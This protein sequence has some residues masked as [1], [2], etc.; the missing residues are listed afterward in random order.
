MARVSIFLTLVLL[1]A[2]TAA[3][4]PRASRELHDLHFGEALYHAYQGEWFEAISRLDTELMQHYGLDEPELDSLYRHVG[5]AEFDVGD[6]ELAYRMHRRAGRAISAVIEG[7]VEAAVRNGA[8]YRLARIYFHKDQPLQAL[9]ALERIQGPVPTE[10]RDDLPFL[11]AQALM[12]SGRFEEAIPILQQLHAARRLEGFTGYN[13][14]VAL[15]SNGQERQGRQVLY[16]TGQLRSDDP[17][18]L[19]IRDKANMVLG[20][21]LLDEADFAAA[22]EVLDRVRLDGPFSNRALLGS[23][24]ADASAGR[25]ER[26]LV[27]WNVLFEREVTDGAVQEALLAV[28]YAYGKLGVY[29]RSALLYG[30]VLETIASEIDKLGAS[31]QSILEGR[32]LEALTREELRHD[33]DW[34]VKLRQLPDSPETYYLLELLASH[35]FQE[36]LRNYLDLDEL[37]DKLEAWRGD[38]DAYEEII[39]LRR[40]YYEPLLPE[41]DS[42]FQ[43]ADSQ[44]RLRLEQRDRVAQ[45]LQNLLVSPHPDSLATAEER[46]ARERLARLERTPGVPGGEAL[47]GHAAQIALLQG[48]LTWNIRTAYHHRLTEAH[49]NL[50]ALHRDVARLNEQY[51]SFVRARQAA[52]QSCEGYDGTIHRLRQR[53]AT[54]LEQVETLLRRQGHLIDVMAV[55]ELTAR[56][57]RL[58]EFQVKAR[59]ALADSYDRASRAEGVK[60]IEQ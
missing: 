57:D 37:R 13:L 34:V 20:E 32:F 56:R 30:G 45:R 58:E 33:S 31:I 35:D 9:A 2:A 53:V 40:R 6:F 17:V 41:I 48:V 7:A 3:A 8:S 44:M 47:P 46:I 25:F 52:T 4:G 50:E 59:F 18:I 54:A 39:A 16:Q 22:K 38:L 15:L 55:N 5:Q 28:P 14:G 26:A 19:A 1:A 49:R 11:R 10:I 27:P 36:S 43:Q 23:G 12:A 29:G 51:T 24:W 42:R 60:G 21:K